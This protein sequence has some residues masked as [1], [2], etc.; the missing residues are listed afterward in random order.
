MQLWTLEHAVT[1]LPSV[2]LMIVVACLLR[3]F[4]IGKPMKIR[5]IPFQ[6]ISGVLFAIE[7]GKQIVSFSRGY[8]LYHIPVHFCSLFIFLLP[9]MSI[10]HGKHEH[11]I[12]AITTGL[13]ASV[14][15]LM[16]IYPSLIY[17]AGNI[18]DFFKGYMDFH[19][20]LFHN[21]VVFAFILI[22]ALDLYEPTEKGDWKK[23]AIF[24]L[25]FCVVS[26]TMAQLL[27]TNYNNFYKCN[28]PPL[29]NL[30]QSM[31]SVLGYGWTQLIYVLIVT[32][33]QSIFVQ[34]S[35]QFYRLVH[36]LIRKNKAT[37]L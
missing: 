13:C 27:Q 11:S 21:I 35:F 33:V 8:D 23:L 18:R 24:Y 28:V 22:V 7:I 37:P 16:M 25:C 34:L 1:L 32:A 2:S 3:H 30:R 26:A 4:L 14:F 29:E 31:Q 19:T 17:S 9:L 6:I 20:V 5:M 36:K 10:Y 12:R 15:L